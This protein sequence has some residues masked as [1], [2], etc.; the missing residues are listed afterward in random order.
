MVLI[1]VPTGAILAMVTYPRFDPNQLVLPEPAT[2]AD[3]ERG[4]GCMG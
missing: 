3:V 1:D 4:A 2:Q